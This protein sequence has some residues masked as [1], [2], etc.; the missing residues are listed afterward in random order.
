MLTYPLAA[1]SSL[2][3][4]PTYA[5]HAKTAHHQT[6]PHQHQQAQHYAAHTPQ[7]LL[8][9]APNPYAS[10]SR[11][12][13]SSSSNYSA[14]SPVLPSVLAAPTTTQT[15][16][17]RRH[18]QQH[19]Q[20]QAQH[21]PPRLEAF[22]SSSRLAPLAHLREPGPPVVLGYEDVR[23]FG[24]PPRVRE[25][26]RG[27][28]AEDG[29]RPAA[30]ARVEALASAVVA[31]AISTAAPACALRAP[32]VAA[33]NGEDDDD[34]DGD[35]IVPGAATFASPR[36][37]VSF[38]TSAARS[39]SPPPV[40]ARQGHIPVT[41]LLAA[42]GPKPVRRVEERRAE[43]AEEEKKE[44]SRLPTPPASERGASPGLEGDPG[45]SLEERREVVV[46]RMEEVEEVQEPVRRRQRPTLLDLLSVPGPL[47]SPSP[48]LPTV[49]AGAEKE[50]AEIVVREEMQLPTPELTPTEEVAAGDVE[51][52][53]DFETADKVY[54]HSSSLP[55]SRL[56]D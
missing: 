12:L 5:F 7:Q 11:T 40:H 44:E 9:R 31:A 35:E 39:S 2:P 8:Q 10:H 15:P 47:R 18:Q 13:S 53:V 19:Q 36:R 29:A 26:G 33:D 50:G 56:T 24:R 55:R 51:A 37:R 54:P 16:V 34:D 46:V 49:E 32:A 41:S 21:A 30:V 14:S 20:Q 48:P 1:P 28:W 4:S 52:R 17:H 27:P 43:R 25:G 42:L 6:Q 23:H 3:S 38:S 45:S 22:A